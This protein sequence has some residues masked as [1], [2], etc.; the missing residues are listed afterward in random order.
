M[1]ESCTEKVE[2]LKQLTGDDGMKDNLEAEVYN[3]DL[4]NEEYIQITHEVD[5]SN[6]GEDW[7]PPTPS[8]VRTIQ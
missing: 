6:S 4:E 5:M 7:R 2:D 3:N 8:T 1:S